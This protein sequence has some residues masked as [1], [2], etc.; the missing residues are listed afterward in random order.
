M[1]KILSLV[2]LLSL[3]T[4]LV[5]CEMDEE[6]KRIYQEKWEL[7]EELLQR[8]KVLEQEIKK[9]SYQL[10]NPH[11]KEFQWKG[12]DMVLLQEGY[13]DHAVGGTFHDPECRKCKESAAH[14]EPAKSE[15]PVQELSD[16]E[17]M[18]GKYE[19]E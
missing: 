18:F 16:Y 13:G 4:I 15:E 9:T 14:Q 2:L 1:R 17:K 12:H 6:T 10:D 19:S 5:S 7:K 8:R 11:V 3:S